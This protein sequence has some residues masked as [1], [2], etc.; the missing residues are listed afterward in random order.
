MLNSSIDARLE[1]ANAAAQAAAAIEK[2][3]S[4][5]GGS[6]YEPGAGERAEPKTPTQNRSS[7][8]PPLNIGNVIPDPTALR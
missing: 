5:P 2:Q 4:R 8:V 3:A 1:I 7:Q 6:A